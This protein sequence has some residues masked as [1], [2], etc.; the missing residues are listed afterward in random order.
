MMCCYRIRIVSML[1]FCATIVGTLLAGQE[2][3]DGLREAYGRL[4]EAE[5]ARDCARLYQLL[6]TQQRSHWPVE[7]YVKQCGGRSKNEYRL[8]SMWGASFA[9]M[10]GLGPGRWL[11][12]GCGRFKHRRTHK[13]L[14]TG[15]EAIREEDGWHFSGIG[16]LAPLDGAPEPCEPK[17]FEPL[18]Q[19][20]DT[21]PI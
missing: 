5:R 21:L 14:A 1:A 10:S 19:S 4:V 2:S 16:L 13:N 6:P 17:D 20:R 18:G 7:D 15:T 9:E 11:V 8:V 3:A 12:T